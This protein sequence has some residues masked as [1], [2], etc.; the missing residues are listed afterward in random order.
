MSFI[1]DK[2]INGRIY[3]YRIEAYRDAK[4]GRPRQRIVEYLGRVVEEGGRKKVLRK[5]S[6]KPSVEEI[7]P[8]GDLALLYDTAMKLD[9]IGTIDRMAPRHGAPTGKSLLLLAINHLAGRIALGDISEWYGRSMLRYWIGEDAGV[10]TEQALLGVL[11]TVC[12]QE[13]D[14]MRDHSWFISQAFRQNLEKLWGNEQRYLYY[15]RTQIVYNG[16]EC[17]W[18]EFSYANASSKERRKIGMGVVVRRGDGF[19]VLYRVYRGNKVDTLTVQDVR[20]RLKF[21]GMK[22]LTVV[23]DRGMASDENILSLAESGYHVIA[24]VSDNEKMFGQM[25]LSLTDDEIQKPSNA[26]RRGGSLLFAC[27]RTVKAAGMSV[28]YVV[29]QN[30]K[31]RADNIAGFLHALEEMKE[32]LSGFKVNRNRNASAP[33]TQVGRAINGFG[34]YFTWEIA[35]GMVEWNVKEDEVRKTLQRLGRSMLLCTDTR[36]PVD[37][38]VHA[39]LE[40]DEVE[41]VWRTGKGALGLN[42]IKH[43]KRDRVVSYLLVCYLAYLLWTAVRQRLREKK[44]DITPDKALSVLKRIEV[45]RFRSS[46][47]EYCEFPRSVGAEEKL[48][49]AF[50]LKQLKD[51]VMVK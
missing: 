3:R 33:E 6:V 24:G 23:M 42:G 32:K 28:R 22:R 7:L 48:Q 5:E 15:D 27:G 34:R 1:V 20:D 35:G 43:W 14:M 2:R 19:P 29:Y 50:E 47:R 38:I 44:F 45:V 39:Y 18:A 41:K 16:G 51:A 12:V 8:F 21:A 49:N 40:K 17:Y 31:T 13:E 37:E 25:V 9:F 26:I 11:D 30:P 36:I 10:F 4:T 46:G